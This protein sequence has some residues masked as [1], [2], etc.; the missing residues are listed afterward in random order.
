MD[1]NGR[2][3]MDLKGR[4]VYLPLMFK[5]LQDT[6]MESNIHFEVTPREVIKGLTEINERLGMPMP[7]HL[8]ANNL[9]HPAAMQLPRIPSK[10][11]TG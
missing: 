11:L 6:E 3:K 1:V 2:N 7:V 4:S 8:H 10:S 5:V 9:G